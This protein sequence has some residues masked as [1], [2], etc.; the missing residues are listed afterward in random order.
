M[1]DASKAGQSLSYF[2]LMTDFIQWGLRQLMSLDTIMGSVE[3]AFKIVDLEHE[4]P[5]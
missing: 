1:K 3:R 5:L 2:I 4:A